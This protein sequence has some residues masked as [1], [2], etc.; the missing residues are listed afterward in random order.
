MGGGKIDGDGSIVVRGVPENNLRDVDVEIPLGELTVFTGVSGS[1][2]SSLVFDTIAAESQRQLND[3]FPAFVR[4]RLP[5]LG[6]PD[7]D[8]IANLSV[9]VVVDQQPFS[10]NARS[11]VGTAG[12]LAP[13]LR[14][15]YSRLGEPHAGYSNVFSF[16]Q[17][18]GMCP[19]CQ[20]LGHVDDVDE[21]ALVDRSLS[22]DGGALRFP[23]FAVG[24][25]YWKRYAHSGLFDNSRPL[26]RWPK[27]QLD[28]LLH[29]QPR[30]LT[31]PPPQWYR[32][33]KFEGVV[34]RF[35]RIYLTGRTAAAERVRRTYAADF[36]RVVTTRTCPVCGGGRL[37]PEVLA[38]RIR[39]V[40]IAEASALP[41]AELRAF[42]DTVD[43]RSVAPV[44]DGLVAGLDQMI[45][46]GLGYLH[47][48][49]VSST[50]SGGEAQRVKLVRHLGSSLTRLIY[51]LDE[52]STGLHPADVT[53]L[54]ALLRRLRDKGNTVLVVEHD[55]DVIA[56][57]D[58]VVDLGPGAG[59]DGGR[60]TFEGT[61]AQLRRASTPTGEWLR[62]RPA[63]RPRPRC[64]AGSLVELRGVTDHNLRGVDVDIPAG[65][66]TVLTGV[67]GSGKSSLLTAA[68]RACPKLHLLDQS[69]LRGSRRSTPLTY[70]DASDALRTLFATANGVGVEWFSANSTGGC[71]VCRGTGV[72]TT[73]LAF[74]DDVDLPC[75]ACGGRRFND[76]ALGH[77]LARTIHRRRP[78]HHGRR[79]AGPVR[80]GRQPAIAGAVARMCRVG[81]GYLGL[82]QSLATLSGGERQRLRLARALARPATAYAMDEPTV[83]LH[84]SDVAR[85]LGLFD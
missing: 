55:P 42:L 52:P 7:A 26:S 48:D 21:D 71:L 53:R 40:N 77:P 4:N 66:L 56:V 29:A 62:R 32:S 67:A 51:V 59:V 61:V 20:G 34:P 70:L 9:S 85:L 2:K 64:P 14:L 11:T 68:T 16:N 38:S 45:G 15:L 31:D 10:G 84:G 30:T 43:E 82:G 49:R 63:L 37:R 33:S 12:D 57:A 80:R 81:L 36:E 60:I 78:R 5:H 74:M 75:E 19:R 6:K 18:A 65:V 76:T 72:V 35:R 27:A 50:L 83:G 1:G 58:H 3:T 41:V 8:E 23:T 22:L 54:T 46:I 44:V 73:E 24:T 25:A 17:P 28:D 69:A 47:A 79:C 39:G 13:L